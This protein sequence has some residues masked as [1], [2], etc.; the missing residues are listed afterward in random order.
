MTTSQLCEARIKGD[1]ELDYIPLKPIEAGR[2][3]LQFPHIRHPIYP[4]GRFYPLIQLARRYWGLEP[5]G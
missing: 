4:K 5:R 2:K 1:E 3:P